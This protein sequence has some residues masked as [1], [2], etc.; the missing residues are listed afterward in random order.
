MSARDVSAR[1]LKIEVP[2]K[3]P[4]FWIPLTSGIRRAEH[5]GTTVSSWHEFSTTSLRSAAD[6]KNF[7]FQFTCRD[8]NGNHIALHFPHQARAKGGRH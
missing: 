3:S 5:F 6:F 4:A 7:V 8:T 1:G 2:N